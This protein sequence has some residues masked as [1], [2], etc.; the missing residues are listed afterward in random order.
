MADRNDRFKRL[1]THNP[2]SQD[3]PTSEEARIELA[4]D[5]LRIQYAEKIV[6]HMIDLTI[7]RN[8]MGDSMLTYIDKVLNQI[9][10]IYQQGLNMLIAARHDNIEE[11]QLI[12]NDEKDAAEADL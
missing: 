10:N 9:Y 7:W 6:K 4:Q 2:S 11:L 5:R 1:F 3:V 8:Q 12:L